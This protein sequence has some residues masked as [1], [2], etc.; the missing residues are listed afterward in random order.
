MPARSE[1][2]SG[3]VKLG[4]P[5]NHLCLCASTIRQAQVRTARKLSPPI[6]AGRRR[7]MASYLQNRFPE[8]S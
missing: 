3:V 2:T 5:W 4:S 7:V 8:V 1:L 6:P